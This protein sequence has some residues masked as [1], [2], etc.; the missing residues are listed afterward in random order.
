[1]RLAYG[2]TIGLLLLV[3]ASC[4]ATLSTVSIQ[5]EGEVT[6]V[7]DTVEFT[8]TIK[9][10]NPTLQ[11][12]IQQTKKSVKDFLNIC[13]TYQVDDQD[14]KT[15][16]INYDKE[17]RYENGKE[18]FVG[19]SAT[20]VSNVVIRK[21]D[22]F[23]KFSEELLAIGVYSMTNMSFS[24]SKI[25]ELS[26]EAN[27][28]AIEAAN[29]SATAIATKLNRSL[30]KVITV[31]NDNLTIGPSPQY[32]GLMAE[33]KNLQQGGIILS[34]GILKINKNIIIIYELN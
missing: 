7:P 25:K 3:L 4:T 5:G 33:R 34:P 27:M 17:Y 10:V 12:S 8:V 18:V 9:F 20:Q 11:Q 21:I 31:Q 16:H 14:I 2:I 22:S 24:T 1:M 6:A 29:K 30:G 28:L 13:N 26:N 19:Y 32:N 15:S 23:E